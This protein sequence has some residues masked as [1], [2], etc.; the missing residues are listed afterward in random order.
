MTTNQTPDPRPSMTDDELTDF[1]NLMSDQ[2]LSGPARIIARLEKTHRVNDWTVKNQ[3]ERK[4]TGR[5]VMGEAV[6]IAVS[7]A[8]LTGEGWQA[9]REKVHHDH[10]IYLSADQYRISLNFNST[11]SANGRILV[12]PSYDKNIHG[13]SHN[14]KGEDNETITV[15]RKRSPAALAA[16]IERRLLSWYRPR[17]DQNREAIKAYNARMDAIEARVGLLVEIAGEGAELYDP[18]QNRWHQERRK[19]ADA[20]VEVGK[21]GPTV[22]ADLRDGAMMTLKISGISLETGLELLQMLKTIRQ[23][24]ALAQAERMKQAGL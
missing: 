19:G 1:L 18:N 22:T 23:A 10:L 7:L 24:E 5:Q 16:D 17:Q 8:E 21:G 2:E 3:A 6:E 20:R 4:L 9:S 12:S 15:S 13:Y 11:W 14:L